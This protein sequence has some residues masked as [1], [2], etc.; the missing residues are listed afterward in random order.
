MA[1]FP[2][3]VEKGKSVELVVCVDVK[4]GKN[5]ELGVRARD[6]RGCECPPHDG[7]REKSFP[8]NNWE[9]GGGRE[10][11]RRLRI[12]RSRRWVPRRRRRWS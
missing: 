1:S 8:V 7:R 6:N 3:D 9:D 12:R 11:G 4:K 5:V 2:L 10:E